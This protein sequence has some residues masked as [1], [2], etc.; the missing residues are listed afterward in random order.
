M[1]HP[2]E[3]HTDLIAKLDAA[4]LG[5]NPLTGFGEDAVWRPADR[6]RTALIEAREALS[7]QEREEVA[8]H[9]PTCGAGAETVHACKCSTPSVLQN[10][11]CLMCSGEDYNPDFDYCRACG[12]RAF[13][14]ASPD[15]PPINE[16]GLA[17]GVRLAR[18]EPD[19]VNVAEA[20]Q[21][22]AVRTQP[23][24]Q[25]G[26][27]VALRG[28]ID[29]LD[30]AILKLNPLTG[31]GEDRIWRPADKVRSAIIRV[32][33]ALAAPVQPSPDREALAATVEAIILRRWMQQR[34]DGFTLQMSSEIADAILTLLGQET[35]SARAGSDAHTVRHGWRVKDFGDGWMYFPGEEEARAEAASMGGALVEPATYPAL[36]DRLDKAI[37]GLNPLTGYG[38]DAVWR[39]ADRARSA[40]IEARDH[41]ASREGEASLHSDGGE[42]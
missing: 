12:R 39:P 23:V 11:S 26:E 28:L 14:S 2:Q 19:P 42:G 7:T 41:I 30:A 29:E 3:D 22:A 17:R 38:E 40:L 33:D 36:I 27:P 34:I 16:T 15:R 1:I 32:R 8:S 21:R 5:L 10:R 6:A 13:Q 25:E 4:I 35:G 9:C 31:E 18:G 20:Y 37:L 24:L